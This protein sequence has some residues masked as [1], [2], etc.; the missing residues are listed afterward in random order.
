VAGPNCLKATYQIS[1][2]FFSLTV[3]FLNI[4]VIGVGVAGVAGIHD[5]A[6][7]LTLLFSLLEGVTA[8]WLRVRASFAHAD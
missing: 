8:V 3:A 1:N 2:S 7:V 6:F 4:R 5:P